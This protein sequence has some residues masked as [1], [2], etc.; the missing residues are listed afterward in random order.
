MAGHDDNHGHGHDDNDSHAT[1]GHGVHGDE[2]DD[3][4]L[5]GGHDEHG[6]HD[7]HAHDEPAQP[8]APP[9]T[10][11]RNWWRLPFD[12]T[13]NFSLLGFF[14]GGSRWESNERKRVDFKLDE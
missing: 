6:A 10:G 8:V 12:A 1:H 3:L 14:L 5:H 9:D 11:N 13:T 2:H 7:V 4:L